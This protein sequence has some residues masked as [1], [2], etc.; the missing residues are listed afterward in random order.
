METPI[1][2]PN[3]KAIRLY[4]SYW[5]RYP[6]LTLGSFSFSLVLALQATIIPLLVSLVLAQLINHHVINIGLLVF[7]GVFSWP[8]FCRLFS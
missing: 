5:K 4:L 2:Q 3:F 6:L 7:A 1:E 8:W